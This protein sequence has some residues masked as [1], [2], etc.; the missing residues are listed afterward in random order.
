MYILI[1]NRAKVATVKT[2]LVALPK[3]LMKKIPVF[4]SLV[5]VGHGKE[6]RQ[7]EN[8]KQKVEQK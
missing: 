7:P 5:S 3:M 2:Q 6:S 1:C 4:H 8:V